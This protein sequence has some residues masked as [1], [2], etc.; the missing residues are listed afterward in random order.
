MFTY[1]Y[2]LP[3]GLNSQCMIFDTGGFSYQQK[4]FF[5]IQLSMVFTILFSCWKVVV[6]MREGEGWTSNM[7]QALTQQI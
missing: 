7:P 3:W 4:E 6:S 5:S 2:L 1:C